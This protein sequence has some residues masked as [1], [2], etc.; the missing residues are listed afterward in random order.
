MK[1]ATL[2]FMAVVSAFIFAFAGCSGDSGFEPERYVVDAGAVQRVVIDVSDRQ[3]DIQQSQDDRVYIDYFDSE[4]E[5]LEIE[6]SKDGQ[7]SVK[8]AFDKDW[9]DFIGTKPS[10]RYRRI[11]VKLPGDMIAELSASTTNEDIAVKSLSF[12]ESVS[13]SSN[14]GNIVCER[15]GVEKGVDLKAKNGNITG[16]IVGGWDDFSIACT[17]K[18]GDCNLP[19]FKDGST[20]TFTADCNNGDIDID[21]VQ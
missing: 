13:L 9:T 3:L 4:K 18:K 19:L 17:I 5:Y 11:T 16:S 8:L 14:G 21:F 10:D 7:L 2:F 6:L 20:K 1:K 15:L 12:K